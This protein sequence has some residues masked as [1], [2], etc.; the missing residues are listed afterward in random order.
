MGGGDAQRAAVLGAELFADA[1]EV[2]HLAHDQLYALQHML[3][4]LGD[5]L[6]AL[7]MARE[8]IHAQLFLELDDGLGDPGL[9]RMQ[10]HGRLGEI[11]V[12]AG[13]FLDE[14]KLMQVHI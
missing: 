6:E 3:A 12:A 10:G 8:N 11:E 13:G 4:G 14:A 1:L 2:A 7:A 9:R 5:A